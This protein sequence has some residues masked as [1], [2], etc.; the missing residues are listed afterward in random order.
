MTT[1]DAND[2]AVLAPLRR[3]GYAVVSDVQDRKH[4]GDRVI[5]LEKGDVRLRIIRERNEWFADVGSTLN[6][7]EQFDI[8]IVMRAVRGQSPLP[9]STR[10]SIENL[11]SC[12]TRA[13]SGWEP[14][15][16][17]EHF[18][19]TCEMIRSFEIASARERFGY[20]PE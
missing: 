2:A 18:H 15:F 19:E 6:D 5:V 14:L 4:F 3:N 16:G 13:A 12:L 7:G 17:R 9:P 8:S 1:Q 20:I 10:A 11:V